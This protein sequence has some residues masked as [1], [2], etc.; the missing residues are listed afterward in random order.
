MTILD[1]LR[2]AAALG[3]RGGAL[4]RLAEGLAGVPRE[5]GRN[6]R[7]LRPSTPDLLRI[8]PGAADNRIPPA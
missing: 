2:G 7:A 5:V 8:R 4:V 1:F 6:R 3:C